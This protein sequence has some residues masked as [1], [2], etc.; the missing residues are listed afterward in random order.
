MAFQCFCLL[1]CWVQSLP[2]GGHVPIRGGLVRPSV[3]PSYVHLA[4][5]SHICHKTLNIQQID[6]RSELDRKRR[7]KFP[8][9]PPK[10]QRALS[11]RISPIS[12]LRRRRWKVNEIA[13]LNRKGS[14]VRGVFDGGKKK[15]GQ[16]RAGLDFFRKVSSNGLEITVFPPFPLVQP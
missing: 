2:F 7:N 9:S 1:V 16:R 12:A 11:V 5:R 3:R 13:K 14:A 10:P 8:G 15:E 6:R 4:D